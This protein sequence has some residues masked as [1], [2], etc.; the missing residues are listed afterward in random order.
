MPEGKSDLNKASCRG[1]FR[2]GVFMNRVGP[3]AIR[4][5]YPDKFGSDLVA[6]FKTENVVDVKY[7]VL[8][9]LE[10]KLNLDCHKVQLIKKVQHLSTR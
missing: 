1:F 7:I 10:F 3:A 4:K 2:K 9:C 5:E 8:L 6:I